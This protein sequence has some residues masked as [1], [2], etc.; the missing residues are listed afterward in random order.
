[1]RYA[2]L[3]IVLAAPAWAH[4]EAVVVSVL[5]SLL[6]LILAGSAAAVALWRVLRSRK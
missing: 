3:L 6:P 4:H 5:P 1:M 2:I